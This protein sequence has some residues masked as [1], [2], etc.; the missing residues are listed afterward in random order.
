MSGFACG[1]WP[2]RK[3]LVAVMVDEEGRP[4]P[5]LQ[6]SRHDE[7]YW[8]LLEHLDAHVGLDSDLVLPDWLA[9]VDGPARLALAR[10]V[11]VWIVPSALI[12]GVRFIGRLGTG[13][14]ART[15]AA[16]ARLPLAP[17]FRP[18]LRRVLPQNKRQLS[19]L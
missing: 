15:A 5:P 9:R 7:G 13:P 19:L 18:H 10:G 16:L 11:P 6:V 17:A 4:G 8:A 3:G 12:E 2:S 1:L 14:P